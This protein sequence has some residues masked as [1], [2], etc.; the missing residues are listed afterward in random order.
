M[1]GFT[2]APMTGRW[3]D[4]ASHVTRLN[5]RGH[6][7]T[8]PAGNSSL[9][10][11]AFQPC[12]LPVALYVRWFHYP[13]VPPYP[14]MAGPSV[15]LTVYTHEIRYASGR[16]DC[17]DSRPIRL[18]TLSRY[19][20]TP[21]IGAC[22]IRGVVPA[23]GLR[24]ITRESTGVGRYTRTERCPALTALAMDSSGVSIRT[25]TEPA[26]TATPPISKLPAVY[27]RRPNSKHFPAK[28]HFLG[29][30]ASPGSSR[31]V[32]YTC[33]SYSRRYTRDRAR[34]E[35]SVF[36]APH[37]LAPNGDTSACLAYGY[38]GRPTNR[39]TVDA[40]LVAYIWG[41]ERLFVSSFP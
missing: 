8:I 2:H 27:H 6:Q 28:R 36:S 1:D 37:I 16:L 30:L 23:A 9:H 39:Q 29:Q 13:T 33:V 17:S 41:A 21:S 3:V 15:P 31:H 5:L 11:R 4:D 12:T 38:V 20:P 40:D 22:H 14:G 25:P 35:N 18:L 10:V 24:R 32:T 7:V 26:P 19:F 34:G